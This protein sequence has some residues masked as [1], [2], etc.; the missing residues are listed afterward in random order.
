MGHDLVNSTAES[1]LVLTHHFRTQHFEHLWSSPLDDG[2]SGKQSR[3]QMQRQDGICWGRQTPSFRGDDT[4]EIR[5]DCAEHPEPPRFVFWGDGSRH[6]SHQE[7]ARDFGRRRPG[8]D[9]ALGF[10]VEAVLL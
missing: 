2:Y 10:I 4:I 5:N 8:S 9:T 6:A 1:C 7:K 3:S